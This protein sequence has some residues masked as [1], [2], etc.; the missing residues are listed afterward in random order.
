M[1]QHLLVIL[2]RFAW[3]VLIAA[4][5]PLS[6]LLWGQDPA[7]VGVDGPSAFAFVLI[8]V[9]LSAAAAAAVLAVTSLAHALLR[10]RIRCV[11]WIDSGLAVTLL[12]LAINAGIT[13]NYS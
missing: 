7:A 8:F 3:A 1:K 13:A 10:K 11:L 4:A 12:A 5:L 9:L 2:G 6:H